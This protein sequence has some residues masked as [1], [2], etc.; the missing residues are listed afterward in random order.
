M[1]SQS[2]ESGLQTDAI[3]LSL[4][5]SFGENGKPYFRDYPDIYFNLSHSGEHVLCAIS[6]EEVGADIQEHRKI[7]AGIAER[8]FS[9]ED[10]RMLKQVEKGIG[11][12]AFR[13]LFYRMWTVKEAH[14]KLTGI[15][16]K[17]G[18]DTTVIHFTEDFGAKKYEKG[19]INCKTE[20]KSGA[21]FKICGKIEMYSIA[22]C[23]Y[24]EIADIYIKEIMLD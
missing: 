3:P 4:S 18:M 1:D 6:R 5:Y 21:Y 14:M 7:K 17:Q 12:A 9:D 16:M 22:V 23:S 2:E 10:R 24:S 15:G 20:Q 19:I 8:F 13:E 11:E